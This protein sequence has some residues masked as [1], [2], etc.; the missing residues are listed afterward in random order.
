MKLMSR[1][2][3]LGRICHAHSCP[4]TW[5]AGCVMWL[6]LTPE[7]WVPW[8]ERAQILKEV[9]A[10][11]VGGQMYTGILRSPCAGRLVRA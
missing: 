3:R 4:W 10:L 7:V 2:A 5:R 6:M 8:L 11:G 9:V 1:L